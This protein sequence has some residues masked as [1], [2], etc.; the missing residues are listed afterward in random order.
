MLL[1]AL[2]PESAA[3]IEAQMARHTDA[4]AY[5]LHYS[6]F[7]FLEHVAGLDPRARASLD[8]AAIAASYLGDARGESAHAVVQEREADRESG[9]YRNHWRRD[10]LTRGAA[11]E[12]TAGLR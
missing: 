6:L 9:P 3:T 4:A 11:P 2:L 12:C 10:H 1:V 8:V 7:C 5:G